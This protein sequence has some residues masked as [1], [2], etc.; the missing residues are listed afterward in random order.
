M[1]Q[2]KRFQLKSYEFRR[3]R[4]ASWS[5]LER[6]VS[7]IEKQGLG[8]LSAPELN[9]LPTLYRA[10]LSSLSVARAISLDRNL[11][12]YL[13]GL[14]ARAYL[15][16]YGARR[17]A[18]DTI[19]QF[20]RVRFPC[21]VRQFR[22]H[23]AL[24]ATI[25]I[26]GILTGFLM[27]QAQP[28]RFYSFVGEE[29]ASGRNPSATTEELR[30]AL[31]SGGSDGSDELSFFAAFLF[32]HNSQV[33][34]LCFA[35]GFAAGVPT[36]LLLFINGLV[37][38]SFASLYH[39][40]GL[41]LELWAWLLPHGVPELSAV[42]LASAAGLVIGQSLVFPGRHQRLENLARRGRQAGVIVVGAVAMLLVA[43]LIE[44]IF[45][46]TVTNVGVRYAVVL[47]NSVLLT[48]W[49]VLCGRGEES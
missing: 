20:F 42:V 47:L 44:G 30:E 40:R 16:V 29:M 46:Q 38:G 14:T 10:A 6:L 2:V 28:D 12:S 22:G 31:Y 41:S 25:F 15:C 26:L 18:R 3:E 5:Q 35:L 43:G 23:V 13:D 21:A 4:E 34:M 32:T 37:L 36:V 17:R 24:A 1:M 49:L 45:R 39:S 8:S 27:T 33:A 19:E 7:R 48:A 9:R 11:V